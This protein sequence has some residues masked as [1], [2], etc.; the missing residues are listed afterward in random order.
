MES[1]TEKVNLLIKKT[2]AM[3][4]PRLQ[5][6]IEEAVDLINQSQLLPDYEKE[7][8]ETTSE[9]AAQNSLEDQSE[10]KQDFYPPENSISK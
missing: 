8:Q 2:L 9:E 1:L 6:E 10:K 7:N 5:K 4:D 3:E